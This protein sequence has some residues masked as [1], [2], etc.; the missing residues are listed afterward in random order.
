MNKLQK[1][2]KVHNQKLKQGTKVWKFVMASIQGTHKT[3][4]AIVTPCTHF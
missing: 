2:P 1:T 4:L 3:V